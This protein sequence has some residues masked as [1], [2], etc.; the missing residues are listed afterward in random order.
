[1]AEMYRQGDVLIMKVDNLPQGAESKDT[2]NRVVLAWGEV[3]GHAHAIDSRFAK[4]YTAQ[5]Q[6]YI[7]VEPGAELVHE[8]HATIA[9]TPGVYRVVQQREYIPGSFRE[10]AD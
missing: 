7:R 5:G 8:E 3:T 2:G 4:M 6:N 10:V 9:L 1:M